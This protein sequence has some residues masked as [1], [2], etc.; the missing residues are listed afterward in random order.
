MAD[1]ASWTIKSVPIETRQKA[2]KAAAFKGLTVGKWLIQAVDRQAN[3]EQANEVIP[4]G[5]PDK[6][7]PVTMTDFDPAAFAAALNATAST[8]GNI[9]STSR[10]SPR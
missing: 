5:K 3:I 1:D 6:P 8:P 4:P 9:G 7:P 10:Q 2:I